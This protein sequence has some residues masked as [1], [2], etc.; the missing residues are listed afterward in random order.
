[1]TTTQGQ[2]MNIAYKESNAGNRHNITLILVTIVSLA[3]SG[4]VRAQTTTTIWGDVKVEESKVDSKKPLSLMLI[5]YNMAG[6]V[7]DRQTVPVGGRYRF[8]ARPGE[9][10]IG[11]EVETTEIARVHI[12]LSGVAGGDFRQDLEFEWKPGFGEARPKPGTISAVDIYKRPA[13]TEPIFR[14]AQAAVDNKKYDEAAALFTQVVAAD[15]Q[16]FQAWS[17]LGTVYLFLKKESEA[18][19]AYVKAIEVKPTFVLALLNLG[20]LRVAQKKFETAID[21]LAR[22]VELQLDSAEGNFLLGEAY[23]QTKKGSKAVTYLTEA[24]KLGKAEA[25]LRLATLYN[26]AGMKDKA[27]AEY[28]EYLRKK[29]DSPDRKK[30][31]QYIEANRAKPSN[32]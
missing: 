3:F 18:E 17:E 4:M 9:Y 8:S 26:A 15:R 28:E 25:H 6:L 27:A 11:V 16:D 10:D 20:R 13:N 7:L 22:V 2:K 31:E 1:M 14:K 19:N 23:L 5:L 30:M 21:P 12:V 24:G 32:P 29:P